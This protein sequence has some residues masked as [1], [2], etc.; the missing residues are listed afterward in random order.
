MAS[1]NKSMASS[2]GRFL[3]QTFVFILKLLGVIFSYWSIV[4]ALNLSKLMTL[5][6]RKCSHMLNIW[7]PNY[8]V[9]YKT[10]LEF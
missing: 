10:R 2:K 3:F 1:W 9:C 8:E 4:F 5:F 7:Q 6:P